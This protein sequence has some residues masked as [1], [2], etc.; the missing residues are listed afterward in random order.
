MRA[1]IG[2]RRVRDRVDRRH[3]LEVVSRRGVH[4]HER[5]AAVRE[6]V[7]GPLA[8]VVL[9][10]V[11]VAQ[12]HGQAVRAEDLDEPVELLE[13]VLPRRE[14]GRE[15]EEVGAEAAGIAERRRLLH[16][17]LGERALQVRGAV[18]LAQVGRQGL[19][20]RGNGATARDGPSRRR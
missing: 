16:E 17:P 11:A 10:P 1:E 5:H 3:D 7:E 18:Q 6:P 14:G 15:L 13:L 19:D 12:L 8:A 4:A 2:D 20:R 9:N